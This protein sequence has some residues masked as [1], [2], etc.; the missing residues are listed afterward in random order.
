MAEPLRL[1]V[2]DDLP[3]YQG[4]LQLLAGPHRVEGGWWHRVREGDAENTKNVT[5]DYW[6]AQSQHCG[7]L[8][9]YHERL[10]G[11]ETRWYLQGSFA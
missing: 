5:R 9:I 6:V 1:A 10:A 3:L 8:W 2:K 4:K 11:D 7:V